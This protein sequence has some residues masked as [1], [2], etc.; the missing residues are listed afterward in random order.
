MNRKDFQT[1]SKRRK[2]EAKVLLDAGQYAGAYY[3]TGYAI[4]CALKACIAKQVRQYDFPNKS[5]AN[6]AFSHDLEK[7]VRVAGFAPEFEKERKA[8]PALKLNW[9]VVKDWSETSRYDLSITEAQARDLFSACT[10]R[11]NGVLSWIKKRW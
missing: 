11:K 2:D 3:L 5:L 6:E 8:N 7:L 10:T 4:E 9:A 1:I